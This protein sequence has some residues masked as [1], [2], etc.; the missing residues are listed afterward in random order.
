MGKTEQRNVAPPQP[1][2]L[3]SLSLSLLLVARSEVVNAHLELE[4]DLPLL[5]LG[6]VELLGVEVLAH[7]VHLEFSLPLLLG[8]AFVQLGDELEPAGNNL[9]WALGDVVLEEPLVALLVPGGQKH[10]FDQALPLHGLLV[11]V[12]DKNGCGGGGPGR[13]LDL[14]RIGEDRGGGAPSVA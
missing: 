11:L 1:S 2:P 12:S 5:G 8:S 6:E 3:S 10:L 13:L 14:L 9:A 4:E 7:V